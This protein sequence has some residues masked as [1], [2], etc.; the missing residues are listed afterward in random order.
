MTLLIAGDI[1]GT[2]TRLQLF[3]T[4]AQG[5][6]PES[7]PQSYPSQDYPDLVPIVAEFCQGLKQK[8][9]R[10]CFAIAGPVA[11]NCCTLTNLHW[12]LGG[13]RLAQALGLASVT[14]INDFV[15]I[16]YG[17]VGLKPQ[18]LHCLQAGRPDPMGAIAVLGAGTG[19]GEA[20]VIPQGNGQYRV[21]PTEGGHTDFAP[22]NPTETALLDYFKTEK[23]LKRVSVERVVSGMG[24]VDIYHCLR[25]RLAIPESPALAAQWQNP[26]LDF[27]AL[28]AQ[29]AFSTNDRLCRATMDCFISAYGAEAGNLALKLLPY[30]GLFIA[31][32]IAPKI[33]PLMEQGEFMAAY[34]DK[35]RVSAVLDSV[36]IQVVLSGDVGL[37]GA[38]LCAAQG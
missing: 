30:G 22:R 11:N 20:V 4:T 15:G 10:A 1:G 34:R 5:V 29:L 19:L 32:G 8:P 14:L 6:E 9:Q 28:I 26:N 3:H 13:D 25:D 27:A 12:Q 36:P 35:G 17:V 16:G 2:N 7:S 33:L 38:A 21:F 23:Q 18:D 31:G 24:I 37:V